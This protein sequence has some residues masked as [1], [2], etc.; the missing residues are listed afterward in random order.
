MNKWS[1]SSQSL[2]SV[3]E[4]QWSAFSSSGREKNSPAQ[5]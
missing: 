4:R 5:V 3:P 1:P 2:P